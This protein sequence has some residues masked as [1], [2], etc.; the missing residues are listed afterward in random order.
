M[1]CRG[2]YNIIHSASLISPI[3]KLGMKFMGD[4]GWCLLCIISLQI[5]TFAIT[6]F[7]D[8]GNMEITQH[9]NQ[10]GTFIDHASHFYDSNYHQFP[11]EYSFAA[12]KYPLF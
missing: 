2:I 5:Y 10:H 4:N 12:P 1:F 11:H 3:V 8:K 7:L 9:K 6:F